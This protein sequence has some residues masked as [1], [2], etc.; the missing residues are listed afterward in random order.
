MSIRRVGH[1]GIY[2]WEVPVRIFHWVHTAGMLA[3]GISGYY[4]GNPFI[5]SA[6]EAYGQHIMEVIRFIHF[7]AA[8]LVTVIFLLRVYWFFVGNQYNNFLALLPT[9]RKKLRDFWRQ[10]AY[11]TF[12]SSEKPEYLGHNPLAGLVYLGVYVLLLISA[13]TGFAL[14]AEVYTG[15]VWRSLFGWAFH[16]A[17]NSTIRLIHHALMWLFLIF[18][19]I[20]LYLAA[21]IDLTERGGIIS[22]IVIGY[23]Y[24]HLGMYVLLVPEEEEQES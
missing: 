18:F 15:G 9:S 24:P 19:I 10:I 7:V 3:L 1:E 2:V 8:I 16:L 23:K 13:I 17:S 21:L 11:Y 5:I 22:S 6:G 4:I 20:H 14:Y 12:I